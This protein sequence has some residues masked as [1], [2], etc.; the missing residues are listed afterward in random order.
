MIHEEALALMM[1]KLDGV[2]SP[3]GAR[4]LE[5]HVASCPECLAEWKALQ[6]VDELLATSP[7]IPAPAGFALRVQAV[8]ETP[9]W[10]RTLATLY[11]LGAGSLA[12]LLLIAVPA[13]AVLLGIWS[14]YNE[15]AA[16]SSML[17]W[18]GQLAR[19]SGSLLE[20]I[21][22]TVRLLVE[23]LATSPVTLAW[24]SLAAIV[25]GV[26]ARA[27]RRPELIHVNGG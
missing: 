23:G 1:D 25:V 7:A 26:W 11:A 24:A 27:L 6:S 10:R 14:I 5:E 8:I 21:W 19:V 15:P 13:A 20:A 9:S 22:T 17:V 16:F 18:L 4:H 2:L 3:A 12:A